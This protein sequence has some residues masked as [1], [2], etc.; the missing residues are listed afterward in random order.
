MCRVPPP[1]QVVVSVHKWLLGLY[2]F[3]LLYAAPRYTHTGGTG[4]LDFSRAAEKSGNRSP[5]LC[6]ALRRAALHRCVCLT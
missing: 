6:V 2:S 1:K 5:S 4:V 3:A